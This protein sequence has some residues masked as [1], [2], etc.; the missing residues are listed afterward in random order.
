MD[1]DDSLHQHPEQRIP[2]PEIRERRGQTAEP[3]E[4]ARMAQQ[5]IAQGAALLAGALVLR[6]PDVLL[7]ADLRWAGDFAELATGAEVEAGGDRRLVRVSVALRFGS[8]ELR[9]TEDLGR[10]GNGTN[11]IAGCALGAG[12]DRVLLFDRVGERLQVVSD[13]AAIASCAAR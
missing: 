10:A 9:T 4:Q 7:D 11:R 13:H 2:V 5:P 8:Q 1:A 3:A 6:A 12:F